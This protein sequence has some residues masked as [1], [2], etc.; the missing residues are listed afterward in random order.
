[1]ACGAPTVARNTVY[2]REVLG[3]AGVYAEPDSLAIAQALE[4]VLSDAALQDRLSTAA[5]ARQQGEYTWEQV[6][7]K[8][9]ETLEAALR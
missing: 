6:C 2:N 1:M 4:S 9:A 7:K 3:D 8:Y 5:I